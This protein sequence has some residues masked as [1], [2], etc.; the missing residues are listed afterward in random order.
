MSEVYDERASIE[1][2]SKSFALASRLLPRQTGRDAAVVYA[3]C[4]RADDAVDEVDEDGP[5][6]I[7]RA[8]GRLRSEL[9]ELYAGAAPA[10]PVLAA[11]AS[12]V[13]ATHI[14][15][16]SDPSR[17]RLPASV[18]RQLHDSLSSSP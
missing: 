16:Q 14:P 6:P 15:W 18:V 7:E 4:R 2:H 1:R 8:L 10:D 13:F 3:W 12:V 17:H 9:G 5:E 11:F